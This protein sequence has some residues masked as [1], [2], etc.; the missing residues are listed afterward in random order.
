V[1]S[2]NVVRQSEIQKSARVL[3][4]QSMFDVPPTENSI[5]EWTVDFEL[6]SDWNIGLIVG[7]SG[8]GK[9]TIAQEL[10]GKYIVAGFDWSSEKAL[11]DDFP[12]ELGIKEITELLGSVGFGTPPNWLKPFHVLSNGEKFRATMARAIAQSSDMLVVDEFTSVIDRQVAQIASHTIQKTIRAKQKRFVAV[13]CH[14]DVIDW[15]QPDW[16]YQPHGNQF[17]R[18]LLRQRP[19]FELKIHPIN[20]ADWQLFKQYHYMSTALGSAAKCF[21]GFINDECIAFCSYVH[22]PHRLSKNIKQAHRIV[23]HPD[24]QGI[25]IGGKMSE[26]MGQYLYS[27]GQRLFFVTAHPSM[28]HYLSKSPRWVHERTGKANG[29]GGTSMASLKAH[30]SAFSGQRI[31]SS[32]SYKPPISV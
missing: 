12:K 26:W 1:Q 16:I 27:Q 9:T 11:I 6:P 23:V 10:F 29:K 19:T 2:I 8:A 15:L 3:Q 24:Y 17:Q 22:F 30:Q 28:L 21:G 18:R 31:S 4:I 7:P 25:G 14:Y 20:R 5:N 13:S 32:F